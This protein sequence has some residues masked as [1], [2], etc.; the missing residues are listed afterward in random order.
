MA[1]AAG[2]TVAA[3]LSPDGTLAPPDADTYVFWLA[4]PD[5]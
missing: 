3:V 2:M 1:V 5:P 4:A